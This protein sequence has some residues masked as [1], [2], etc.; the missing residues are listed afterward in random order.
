MWHLIPD[1]PFD[2]AIVEVYVD[3]ITG[4]VEAVRNVCDV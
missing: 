3:S 4:V 2:G 1:P